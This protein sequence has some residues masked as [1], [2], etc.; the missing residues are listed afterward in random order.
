MNHF[1]NAL[2][3]INAQNRQLQ[4]SF[5]TVNSNM[6][7]QITN[8]IVDAISKLN[9]MPPSSSTTQTTTTMNTEQANNTSNIHK[10]HTIPTTTLSPY[11]TQTSTVHQPSM[12]LTSTIPTTTPTNTVIQSSDT[13]K[14][15]TI[16]DILQIGTTTKCTFP[17]YTKVQNIHEW[18]STCLLELAASRQPLHQR[19]IQYDTAGVPNINRN[20]SRQESQELFRL[21]RAALSTKLNTNFITVEIIKKADGI[22]LWDMLIQRFQLAEKDD[23]E[24]DDMKANFRNF[25]M[26]SRESDENNVQRF[27]KQ[28][29]DMEHFNIKPSQQL[30]VI[31]FLSGLKD[32]KLAQP[33]MQLRQSPDSIY[34]DWIREGNIRHTL[35]KA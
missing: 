34:K 17:T 32:P 26:L 25:A 22:A 4:Q 24:L 13:S 23:I 16:A 28:I 31:I 20:L 14:P 7:D 27:E 5:N 1:N 8:A 29:N 10:Q 19:M 3:E 11:S 6:Q 35:L 2:D 12:P 18:L 21:T 9:T 30:Q 15:L 33:I